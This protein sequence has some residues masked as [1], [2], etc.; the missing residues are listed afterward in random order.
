MM[1]S[2]QSLKHTSSNLK[3]V[4]FL[5]TFIFISGQPLP[6]IKYTDKE[7]ETWGTVLKKLRPLYKTHACREHLYVFPLLVHNCGY[8]EDNIPQLED[9]SK[10]LK[11]TCNSH[12]AFS[13]IYSNLDC[14][15]FTLRPVMGLLSSRDFL[16]G[17][18]FRVFHSTQ[19]IRHHSQPFYTPE[20]DICHELLGHVPLYADADFAE[21]SHEIGLASLGASDEDI[22]KLSTIYWFTGIVKK[23]II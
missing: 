12:T 17:L 11:G 1:K 8:R 23:C 22:V 21:F 14:T 19:Y 9:I 15:G 20:P 2:Q 10:F 16:N 4:V 3:Y 5:S 6:R 13:N 18:A 7:V